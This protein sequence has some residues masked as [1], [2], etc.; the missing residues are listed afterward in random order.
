M[1]KLNEQYFE[2]K[3]KHK[4]SYKKGGFGVSIIGLL[5][6]GSVYIYS[7][8]DYIFNN[9]ETSPEEVL[10][11]LSNYTEEPTLFDDNRFRITIPAGFNY[12]TLDD[13]TRLIASD[14]SG[15]ML[16]VK[17]QEY[18]GS[19]T[20]LTER[21]ENRLN[22]SNSRKYNL[23]LYELDSLNGV[24]T[25][26]STIEA[27]DDSN[28]FEGLIKLIHVN[29]TIYIIQGISLKEDWINHSGEASRF[30]NSFE[31]K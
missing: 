8:R 29:S 6:V 19:Y 3:R 10:S 26:L 31:R 28:S 9:N 12:G 21:W 27:I 7:N 15:L 17:V 30:I 23:S 4:E 20:T 16:L 5:I 22:D 1:N 13:K 24:R 11:S 25:E 2:T 18:R 14:S